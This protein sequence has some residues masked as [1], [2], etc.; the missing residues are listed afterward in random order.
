MVEVKCYIC[1]SIFWVDPKYRNIKIEEL[2]IKDPKT[3]VAENWT[4]TSM[5]RGLHCPYCGNALLDKILKKI[6]A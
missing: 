1:D 6:G 3:Y 4:K 2:K 5:I